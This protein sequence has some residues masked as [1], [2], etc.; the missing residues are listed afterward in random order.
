MMSI[1]LPFALIASALL[2]FGRG[3]AGGIF[4]FIF[5]PTASI[6]TLWAV[7]VVVFDLFYG[8]DGADNVS[9]GS[10]PEN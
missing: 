2:A 6:L 1:L 5:I 8:P 4:G 10:K 7:G 3:G 9:K